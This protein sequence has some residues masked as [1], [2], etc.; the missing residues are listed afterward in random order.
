MARQQALM[1]RALQP[2]WHS[3]TTMSR[4][5]SLQPAA[6]STQQGRD[7]ASQLQSTAALVAVQGPVLMLC[8]RSMAH[9]CL[10][11]A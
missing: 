9:P 8:S 3:R 7:A 6:S 2:V 10:W 4:Q 5:M 1:L 11:H